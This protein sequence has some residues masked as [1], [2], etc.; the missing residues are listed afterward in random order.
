MR[1]L[2]LTH[3]M[4]AVII[5]VSV[6]TLTRHYAED[7]ERGQA[8]AVAQM[9]GA[10]FRAGMAGSLGAQTFFL[11]ARAGWGEKT[12]VAHEGK[13][14]VVLEHSE[15]ADAAAFAAVAALEREL[16][17]QGYDGPAG[18]PEA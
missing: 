3:E 2:G 9:A 6:D 12:V 11:R 8:S 5:G 15:A 16:I 18:E 1:G 13:L 17:E 4:I 7:M 10:L 14:G